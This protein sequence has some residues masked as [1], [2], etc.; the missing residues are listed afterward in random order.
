MIKAENMVRVGIVS[1]VKSDTKQVRVIYPEANNM[2]SGW[3]YVLQRGGSSWVPSVK[4]LVLCLLM[5]G[6]ETDGYVLGAIP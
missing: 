4:T 3:L 1:S 5:C 2:V 6:E